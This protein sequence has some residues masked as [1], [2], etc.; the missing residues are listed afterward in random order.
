[1]IVDAGLSGVGGSET[2]LL[3]A[4]LREPAATPQLNASITMTAATIV[5]GGQDS[6]LQEVF[7]LVADERPSSMAARGADVG[8]GSGAPRSGDARRWWRRRV[9]PAAARSRLAQRRRADAVVP[10]ARRHF[11]AAPPRCVPR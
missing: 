10:E 6:R 4:L 3:T 11:R 9:E 8:S 2:A 1:M 5:R 7:A